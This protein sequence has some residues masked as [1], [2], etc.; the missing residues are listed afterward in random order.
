[1][2]IQLSKPAGKLC[3]GYLLLYICTTIHRYPIFSTRYSVRCNVYTDYCGTSEIEHGLCAC[4]VDNPLAKARGLSLRT[5]AQT[6]LY[7]SLRSFHSFLF[8]EYKEYNTLWNCSHA[9]LVSKSRES[10]SSKNCAFFLPF[11]KVCTVVIISYTP[12]HFFH[13]SNDK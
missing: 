1:M 9:K 12:C 11:S 6:M 10:A 3:N 2:L 4:T 5:G 8:Q 13:R 7:L